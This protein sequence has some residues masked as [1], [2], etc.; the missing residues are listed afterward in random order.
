MNPDLIII[1]I[2][3]FN[4]LPNNSESVR[5]GLSVFFEGKC[6]TINNFKKL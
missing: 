2:F 1:L 5:D 4:Y 3:D 6:K